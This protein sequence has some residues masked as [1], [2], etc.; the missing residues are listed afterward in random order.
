MKLG[1]KTVPLGVDW[2]TLLATWE[3]GDQ[4]EVFD[5]GWLN[6]HFVARHGHEGQHEAVTA[7]AAIAGRTKRLIL[8]HAVLGNAYRHPVLLAKMVATLDLISAGR[9]VVGLGAGVQND[10]EKSMYGWPASAIGERLGQLEETV[11]ILKGLWSAP[12]GY[13]FD[14]DHYAL[15]DARLDPPCLTV[16]G[17]PVWLGTRGRRGLRIVARYA[18]GLAATSDGWTRE[19][20]HNLA[21]FSKL[22]DV[23]RRHCDDARRDFSTIEISVRILTGERSARDIIDEADGL[24]RAGANHLILSFAARLGPAELER[25]AV[26]VARPMRDQL[27]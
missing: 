13:S 17:P 19:E 6:D 25:L 18:D 16:G 2:P 7:A 1:F 27:G 24:A 11:Q 26:E 8:G 12:D 5:S 21:A 4:L 22:L 10:A 3:L 15:R 20:A 9:F 14:G 23:L